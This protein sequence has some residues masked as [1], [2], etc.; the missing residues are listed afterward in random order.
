MQRR[1]QLV[2]HMC[3]EHTMVVAARAEDRNHMENPHMSCPNELMGLP[4][5]PLLSGSQQAAVW[6][7]HWL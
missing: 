7:F 5:T 6:H 4:C 3:A 1:N 2:S